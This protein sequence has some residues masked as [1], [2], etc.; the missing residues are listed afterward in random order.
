MIDFVLKLVKIRIFRKK[1][2]KMFTQFFDSFQPKT[3]GKI[4][5]IDK[6]GG[7]CWFL[8]FLANAQNKSSKNDRPDHF[9]NF[10]FSAF[11]NK[12]LW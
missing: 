10:Q 7:F 4:F 1:N 9:I 2:Q 8:E 5:P 6:F 11:V 12:K 3:I